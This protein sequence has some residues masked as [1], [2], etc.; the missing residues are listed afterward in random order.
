MSTPLTGLTPGMPIVY[1][2]NR[3]VTVG[4]DLAAAFRPGDRLVVVQDSG[5]LLHIPGA[6]WERAG[7][8]V[9]AAVAAFTRMGS[10]Y[11]GSAR[12]LLLHLRLP[13]RGRR[14]LRPD[15]RGQ[16]RRRGERTGTGAIDHPTR[17]HRSNASRHDRRAA[18]VGR[19]RRGARGG[20]RLHRPRGLDDR[21]SAFGV[22]SGRFRLRRPSQCLRRRNRG[23][24]RWEHG[25]LSHRLGRPRHR[26][27]HHGEC[28]GP[29]ARRV[30]S[31]GG[32]GDPG[33]LAFACC[34]MGD[35]LRS[36]TWPGHR[37]GL[38][39]RRR[40]ARRRRPSD[41][42]PG[43]TPWHRRRVARGRRV[44][45]PGCVRLRGV[46]LA[47]SQGVQHPQHRVSGRVG[48]RRPDSAVSRRLAPCRG[49]AGDHVEALGDDVGTIPR[50]RGLA[51]AGPHRKSGGDDRRAT[52]PVDR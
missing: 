2:G 23:A 44:G 52:Y 18:D 16:R 6:E 30:G 8:A 26:P 11:R 33:R 42:Y 47:R 45:G 39:A 49:A 40:P 34:R 15:R 32:C 28:P 5:D 38:R 22:G 48:R 41:G 35:V 10:A 13:S 14:G 24:R 9:D 21:T 20:H 51:S 27:G 17:S 4:E 43:L 37:P 19:R 1:G 12:H 50:S 29:S 46:Q 31:A 7:E 25:R 3:V 36:T